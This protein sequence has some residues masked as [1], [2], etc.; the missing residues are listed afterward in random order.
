MDGW[1]PGRGA[2]GG[3]GAATEDDGVGLAAG[4]GKGDGEGGG[5]DAQPAATVSTTMARA[6]VRFMMNE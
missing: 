6:D 2:R 4:A 1:V 5:D 3:A